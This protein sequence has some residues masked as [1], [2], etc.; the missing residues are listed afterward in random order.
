VVHIK[1]KLATYVHDLVFSGLCPDPGIPADG[2]RFDLDFRHN[3]SVRFQCAD[4]KKLVGQ[5][6]ITCRY[7]QWN[8]DSPRCLSG[9]ELI[10]AEQYCELTRY[11]RPF[12]RSPRH[13]ER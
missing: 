6:V 10:V 11:N 3:K 13:P 5:S 9:I 8:H 4:G 1:T 12:Y 2:Y 7:G